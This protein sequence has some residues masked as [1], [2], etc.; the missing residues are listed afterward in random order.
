MNTVIHS[1]YMEILD[2]LTYISC[3]DGYKINR[4]LYGD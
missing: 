4:I 1:F 2:T 3:Q